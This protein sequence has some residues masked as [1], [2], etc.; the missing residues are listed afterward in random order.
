MAK[1]DKVDLQMFNRILEDTNSMLI[2]SIVMLLI[3]TIR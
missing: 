1:S 3:I 2:A